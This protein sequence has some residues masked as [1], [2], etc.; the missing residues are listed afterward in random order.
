MH[1]VALVLAKASCMLDGPE[2][3]LLPCVHWSQMHAEPRG[4]QQA[5]GCTPA[6]KTLPSVAA[7]AGLPPQ[8]MYRLACGHEYCRGCLRQ[9]VMTAVDEQKLIPRCCLAWP[10]C[11]CKLP[12]RLCASDAKT[13][14]DWAQ[15][16]LKLQRGAPAHASG[17]CTAHASGACTV[18][19][20]CTAVFQH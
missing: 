11:A 13:K 19:A 1:D 12:P 10:C 14:A 3:G 18:H 8:G 20:F 16:Q 5:A 17:A 7:A 15:Q 9:H 4:R 6:T 2:K